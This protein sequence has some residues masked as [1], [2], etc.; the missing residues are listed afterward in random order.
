[1][2]CILGANFI[3]FLRGNTSFAPSTGPKK[4]KTQSGFS[5]QHR[6][7][8]L[9][10]GEHS[11]YDAESLKTQQPFK[12]VLTEPWCDQIEISSDVNNNNQFSLI[13]LNNF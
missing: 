5:Q 2:F 11:E 8:E 6:T 9:N 4:R 3:T 13:D 7:A 12:E 1:M 10:S